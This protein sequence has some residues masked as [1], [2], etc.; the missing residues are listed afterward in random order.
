MLGLP[1]GFR[2]RAASGA[3]GGENASLTSRVSCAM[4]EN[5][6]P[7]SPESGWSTA[8]LM[9]VADAVIALDLEGRIVFINPAAESLTGWRRAEAGGRPIAEVFRIIDEAT[10]GPIPWFR[11]ESGVL[12]GIVLSRRDGRTVS[13]EGSL[14]PLPGAAG[15]PGGTV[16]VLRAC[17]DRR[18]AEEAIRRPD[19]ELERRAAELAASN[20]ALQA[21]I[22]DRRKADE[23]LE[24]ANRALRALIRASP[25]AIVALDA[26]GRVTLWNPAAERI[27]GWGEGEVL[28]RPLPSVPEEVRG[29][30]AAGLARSLG[31]GDHAGH[32]TR[33]VRRD[34]TTIDVSLWTAPLCDALGEPCGRLG[35]VEDI[36]ERKRAEEARTALLRRIV[37]AQEEERHRIARELHDQMGQHLAALMLGLGSLAERV[38]DSVAAAEA[39][40]IHEIADRIGQDVHRIALELRPTALDDWGLEKA[41]TNYAAEWCRRAR[42][43]LQTR[44]VGTGHRRLPATVE[45]AL[46]RTVQEA[47]T[48]V[49]KHANAGRV[50]LIVERRA[51]DILAIVEDDGRGFEVEAVMR[52]PDAVG[53]LGL[54]GMQER[55]AL[56]GGAL[57]IESSPGGGTSLFVRIPLSDDGEGDRRG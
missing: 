38:R 19:T 51:D 6:L 18:P 14:S 39:R 4:A 29:E 52:A 21:E 55:V 44:F 2:R 7:S 35:L 50:S 17:D 23:E 46:Y 40:R 37:T 3:R 48:N 20:A 13:I 27:F 22:A 41:L 26:R 33:R 1:A 56:V 28:G 54:L 42:V 34:G 15:R 10:G 32:E 24:R 57:E 8:V 12:R 25:L 43:Q 45:T 16:V 9:N 49:F 47:M 30:F 53:R 36:T 5:G 31:G 11:S